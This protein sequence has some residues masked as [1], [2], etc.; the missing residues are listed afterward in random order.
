MCLKSI[1][2]QSYPHFEV[3]LINDGSTD[4]SKEIC[5]EFV[6]RDKRFK[7]IELKDAGFS[8]VRNIGILN[9]SGE[10]ITFIN[11]KDFV[12]NNYLK[13]LY[14]NSVKYNSEIVIGSYNEFNEVDNNYYFYAGP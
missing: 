4:N 12:N 8:N 6:F 1:E 10:F 3:I 7:Y 2:T 14:D 11:G 5:E 9:S 13:E